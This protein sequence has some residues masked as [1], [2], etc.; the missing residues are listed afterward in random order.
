M[1]CTLVLAFVRVLVFVPVLVDEFVF[2]HVLVLLGQGVIETNSSVWY[3]TGDVLFLF[4]CL[5]SYPIRE[6]RINYNVRFWISGGGKEP[7][8]T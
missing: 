5:Q 1:V 4:I 2:V 6:F 8:V 3:F 7:W